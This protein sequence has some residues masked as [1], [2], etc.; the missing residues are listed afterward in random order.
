MG[1]VWRHTVHPVG[2]KSRHGAMGF[3]QFDATFVTC[4]TSMAA[5]S[6]EVHTSA[7]TLR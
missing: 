1:V 2:V 6:G 7:N 4:Q 5:N 3:A